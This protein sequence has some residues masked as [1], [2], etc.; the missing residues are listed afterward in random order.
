[1]TASFVNGRSA[2]ASATGGASTGCVDEPCE[3]AVFVVPHDVQLLDKKTFRCRGLQLTRLTK[4]VVGAMA[5]FSFPPLNQA[6][7]R[8]PELGVKDAAL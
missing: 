3:T 5:G 2:L 4:S 7:D 6:V 1:M 8:L